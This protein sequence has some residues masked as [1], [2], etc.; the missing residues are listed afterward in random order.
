MQNKDRIENIEWHFLVCYVLFVFVIQ[1]Q[2][3]VKRVITFQNGIRTESTLFDLVENEM[4]L[5][6]HLC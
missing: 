6:T 1:N 4:Q 2:Q 3:I 5:W